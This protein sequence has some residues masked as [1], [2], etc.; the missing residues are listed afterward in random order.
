[1]DPGYVLD[2][3]KRLDLT[4]EDHVTARDGVPIMDGV[5]E[6]E[7]DNADV[8]RDNVTVVGSATAETEG[9]RFRISTP[10]S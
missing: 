4:D 10:S 3:C 2:G 8:E 9:T 6:A 7:R 1:L 5:A